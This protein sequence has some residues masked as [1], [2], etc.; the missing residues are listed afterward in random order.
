MFLLKVVLLSIRHH[1]L[2]FLLAIIGLAVSITSLVYL[3]S[4]GEGARSLIRK[5]A[6]A[7]NLQILVLPPGQALSVQPILPRQL[8]DSV[9]A[10]GVGKVYAVLRLP[11]TGGF[12]PKAVG[13]VFGKDFSSLMHFLADYSIGKGRDLTDS[14]RREAVVG[15]VMAR[16]AGWKIGD[17]VVIGTG[18]Y[19]IVG[20]A[21]AESPIVD[22]AIIV[23][24]NLLM[25]DMGTERILA[26][27]VAP[28]PERSREVVEILKKRF[29]NYSVQTSE[30]LMKLAQSFVAM[31]DAIRFGLSSIALFVTA[32]FLFAIMAIT[33]QERRWEFSV[34]RALG[35]TRWFIFR[36]VIVQAVAV[37]VIGWL[38][39]VLLGWGLV[40][41][42]G[43]VMVRVFGLNLLDMSAGIVLLSLLVAIVVGFVGSV[44]PAVSAVRINIREGLGR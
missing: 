10:L 14:T 38:L 21:K 5:N 37:S 40:E 32:V 30:D 42:S 25:E 35:A 43:K 2:R 1:L 9:R 20:I 27:A 18:K 12:P 39:G 8:A 4:F 17:T 33:V 31:G 44:F 34:L 16:T 26:V 6:R 36:L 23:P 24:L 41:V 28:P 22:N 15:S 3:M 29:P 13:V 11:Y 7:F 19:V